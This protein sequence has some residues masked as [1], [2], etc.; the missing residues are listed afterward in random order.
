M[1]TNKTQEDLELRILKENNLKEIRKGKINGIILRTKAR[2]AA[3]GEKVTKYFCNLE[4]RHFISKQMFKL[5]N[6]NGEE[7]RDTKKMINETKEF[8]EQLY[9]KG[10][11]LMLILKI[12]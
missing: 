4:K 12:L 5:I 8:Y 6:K 2:W 10:K 3:Q 9:K 7:I 11:C 1:K